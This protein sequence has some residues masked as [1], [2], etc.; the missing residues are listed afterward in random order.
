MVAVI[1]PEALNPR[2]EDALGVPGLQLGL[3]GY[4]LLAPVGRS[5]SLNILPGGFLAG[6]LAPHIDDGHDD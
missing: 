2:K 4:R 1:A 3:P 6:L 5:G